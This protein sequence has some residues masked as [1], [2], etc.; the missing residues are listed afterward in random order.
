MPAEV[1]AAI[2]EGVSLLVGTCDASLTP[3]CLRATGL[4]VHEDGNHVTVYLPEVTSRNTVTDVTA[5][6]RVAVLLS[7]PLTHRSF[8]LKGVVTKLGPAPEEALPLVEEYLSGFA[9]VLETVGMP[10]EVV[11][12]ISHWPSIALEVQVEEV[13]LQT[14]GPGAGARISGAPCVRPAAPAAARPKSARPKGP[15][16]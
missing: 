2:G 1:L 3:H 15:K 12:M 7:Q 10:Y 4:R 9:R 5:N 16:P 13:F 11:T 6:P 14:P 8:Q